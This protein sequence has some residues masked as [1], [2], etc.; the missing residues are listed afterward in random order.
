VTGDQRS[1]P[2]C[3]DLLYVSTQGDNYLNK[4]GLVINEGKPGGFDLGIVHHDSIGRRGRKLQWVRFGEAENSAP[5]AETKNFVDR[6]APRKP[7]PGGRGGFT[8]EAIV[9]I[10]PRF[11]SYSFLGSKKGEIPND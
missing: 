7:R 1:T 3:R 8:S 6:P 10:N 11:L 2:D 5:E 4:H 9:R